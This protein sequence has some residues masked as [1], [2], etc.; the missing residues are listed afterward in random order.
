MTATPEPEPCAELVA[1]CFA[2]RTAAH[3][4]HLK[5][6]SYAHH[7][8]LESFYEEIIEVADRFCEVYQG[9]HEQIQ[10]YPE[11]PV[12]AQDPLSFL[13]DLVDWLRA[14]RDACAHGETSLQNIVDEATAVT[15]RT[16][17]KLRF[18]K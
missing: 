17:Y 13:V 16:I 12:S 15:A 6:R 18:L 10:T 14:N 3:L 8:A 7:V 1:R 2:A 5:T 4:T 9:L 11:V